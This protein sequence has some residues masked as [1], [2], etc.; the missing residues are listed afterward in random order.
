MKKYF[1][2]LSVLLVMVAFVEIATA[3]DK[4]STG[5]YYPIGEGNFD[6]AKGP[7]LSK[8]PA[9]FSGYYHNG[10]DMMTRTH[11]ENNENSHVYAIAT[12]EVILVSYNSDAWGDGNAAIH[13]R[14]QTN[15]G[16]DFVSVYGHV[17]PASGI[18]KG[19][20]IASGQYLGYTGPWMGSGTEHLHFGI[21]KGKNYQ[22][23]KE[24]EYGWGRIA[25]TQ[26]HW[27]A[28]DSITGQKP[29]TN[30]FV[31]PIDFI[32]D[33]SP[34]SSELKTIATQ[35]NYGWTVGSSGKC[36]DGEDHYRI[37]A[38]G[39][40]VPVSKTEAC[41]EIRNICSVPPMETEV[42]HISNPFS[43]DFWAN[44]WRY[45]KNEAIDIFGAQAKAAC[46]TH[47]SFRIISRQS[48]SMKI[49]SGTNSSLATFSPLSANIGSIMPLPP[50]LPNGTIWSIGG[51]VNGKELNESSSWLSPGDKIELH[52]QPFAESGNISDGMKEGKDTI[53]T[54]TYV[55][56]AL[57]S[58]QGK[59]KFLGRNYTRATT[60]SEG[61]RGKIIIFIS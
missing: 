44:V 59:W 32:R 33:K 61:H 53:E 25:D 7:W 41:T 10:V 38:N 6:S 19:K 17:R 36:E 14:H 56:A 8:P 24:G 15:N 47:V 5:F 27:N 26:V 55:K 60:L 13:I 34:S 2:A 12:G 52:I 45:I 9:Y 51:F 1:C 4:T 29:F 16:I 42:N 21:S 23:T 46:E 50:P 43:R 28:T 31:D 48:G 58:D 3:L 57:D 40:A 22:P 18:G 49:T 54:D 30:G 37:E 20:L 35:G 39:N 11:D